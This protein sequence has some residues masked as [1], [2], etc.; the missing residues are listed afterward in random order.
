M[1]LHDAHESIT[2]DIPTPVKAAAQATTQ[3]LLDLRIMDQYFPG[4]HDAFDLLHDHVKRID[5]NAL[6]VEALRVGPPS[7]TFEGA[8]VEH[9]GARPREQDLKVWDLQVQNVMRSANINNYLSFVLFER[10]RLMRFA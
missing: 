5:R 9:F 1:L 4:G 8:V 7:I 2:G 3:W 6:L 10:D